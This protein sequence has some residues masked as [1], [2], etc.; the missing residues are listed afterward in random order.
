[1][2]DEHPVSARLVHRLHDQPVQVGEDVVA[3]LGTSADERL[4]LTEDGL[5]VEEEADEIG[6]IRIYGLVVGHPIPDSDP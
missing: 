6:H 3:F 5:F 1:L 2:T 4:H